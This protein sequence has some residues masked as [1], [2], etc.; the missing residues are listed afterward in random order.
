MNKN[1]LKDILKRFSKQKILVIGD[2]VADEY[3]L[4]MTSRVSREAPVLVLKYD[5][6]TVLP[7]CAANAVNN[8][9][10]LGGTVFPVGVVGNDEMGKKLIRFLKEKGVDTEGIISDETR[11]TPTKTRIL[12]G[13]YNTTKQQVIRIDRENNDPLKKKTEDRLFDKFMQIAEK[14][15]AI[16]VSDY[17]LGAISR[18][19]LNCI[20][21]LA[22]TKKKVITLDSRFDIFKYRH[23]MAATPN[24]EEVEWAL[25]VTL[26]GDNI[27]Q[28][29][30][31]ILKRIGSDGLLITRGKEG[32]TLF[33]KNG[34]ITDIAIYGTDQVADVTG[35]GDTVISTFT[36]ALASKASMK[37]AAR[38]ANYAGGI[39][40]MKSGTATVTTEEIK[41]AIENE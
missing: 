26:D 33:E 32:M 19:I 35:A 13:G 25:N 22:K 5:S 8:V 7:G 27:R 40:V 10:S 15:D 36:L 23:I 38:L 6:Q 16:L 17:G 14:S 9:H 11:L 39:V 30:R 2:M 21:K 3:I 34:D 20:N 24:S 37:D 12:A 41:N 28:Y 1:R 4:G 29:G 31:N 18:N